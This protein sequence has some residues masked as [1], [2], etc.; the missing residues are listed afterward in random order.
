MPPEVFFEG[1]HHHNSDLFSLGMIMYIFIFGHGM[2]P[3]KNEMQKMFDTE[4]VLNRRV[5]L[6]IIKRSKW[7]N[8]YQMAQRTISKDST[9]LPKLSINSVGRITIKNLHFSNIPNEI[10]EDPKEKEALFDLLKSLLD[11]DPFTRTTVEEILKHPFLQMAELPAKA[12]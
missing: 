5:P 3:D 1:E 7:K 9:C 12:E 11:F 6:D 4:K 10:T 2:F 8:M